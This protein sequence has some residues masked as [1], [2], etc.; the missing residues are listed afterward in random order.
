MTTLNDLEFELVELYKEQF[1]TSVDNITKMKDLES[2]IQVLE[3]QY[4][5]H[6]KNEK[7]KTKFQERI[8]DLR[9]DTLLGL[10]DLI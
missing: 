2:Q 6:S 10:Y 3:T 7:E 4:L 8:G 9:L 1:I 5:N